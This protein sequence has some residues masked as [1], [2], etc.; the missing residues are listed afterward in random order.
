MTLDV[1]PLAGPRVRIPPLLPPPKIVEP[2]PMEEPAAAEP[3]D[4]TSM[5]KPAGPSAFSPD[6]PHTLLPVEKP[7]PTPAPEKKV[8][9]KESVLVP[10]DS[11]EP[12]LQDAVMYFETPVGPRGSRV[13]IPM[14][15]SNPPAA[16]PQPESRATYRKD[17][18]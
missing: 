17:K 18:E 5:P 6:A 8:E 16:V 10:A 7:A 9:P 1:K 4:T 3:A 13:T 11:G 2:D 12:D 14:I 15:P